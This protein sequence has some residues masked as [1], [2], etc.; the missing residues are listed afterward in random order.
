MIDSMSYFA[1]WVTL[2][3]LV[4]L[5]WYYRRTIYFVLLTALGRNRHAT[6]RQVLRVPFHL[7][8]K[9]VRP[10]HVSKK[11]R[12]VR[13][14]GDDYVLWS[15]PMGEF[16]APAAMPTLANL[17]AEQMRSEYGVEGQGVQKGD[18]V[19]DGGANIGVFARQ[20]LRLG[21][22]KVIAVE[23]SAENIECLRRNF[24]KEIETGLLCIVEKGLWSETTTLRFAVSDNDQTTNKLVN[25][26]EELPSAHRILAVPVT[27]VD[28]IQRDLGLP[29]LDFIK[30]DIE[31]AERHALDG[32]IQALQ[33][34]PRLAMAMY[35]LEDDI[36]VLP[37]KVLKANPRYRIECGMC[38]ADGTLWRL[39]PNILF[40][41]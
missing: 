17:V 38:L 3:L 11:L 7:P 8:N 23:P 28:E 18:V 10:V 16:W 24:A 37:K 27:T 4:A 34:K 41:V 12:M 20:A 36:D 13:T 5:A 39:R 6:V 14:D 25:P 22:R 35:H 9:N 33:T 21:A 29:R 26:G 1:L 30:F 40:F 2:I 31:G 19:L 15:T 32:A